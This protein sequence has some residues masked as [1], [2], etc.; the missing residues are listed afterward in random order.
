MNKKD[1]SPDSL[2]ERL[3][4]EQFHVTQEK[5]TERPFTRTSPSSG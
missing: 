4:P 2:H 5:G 3:T 1:V